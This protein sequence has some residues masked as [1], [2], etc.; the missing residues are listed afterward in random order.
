MKAETTIPCR[1]S[2][3]V[4]KL[5][6]GKN[7]D[8]LVTITPEHQQAFPSSNI[9]RIAY[10]IRIWSSRTG[11]VLHT[12]LSYNIGRFNFFIREH[13]ASQLKS[14]FSSLKSVFFPR[15]S[16]TQFSNLSFL[17]HSPTSLLLP[18]PCLFC[19]PAVN[20]IMKRM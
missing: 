13:S 7:A 1:F 4:L 15:H 19:F 11:N 9:L 10:H 17:I 18:L 2:R 12:F 8:Y 14:Q 3:S 20:S 16:L 6:K 5:D